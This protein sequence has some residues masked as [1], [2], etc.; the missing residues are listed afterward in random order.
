MATSV[1]Q[2]RVDDTLR[3]QAAAVYEELGIDLPTAI[4][5]FLKRS[6]AVNGVPFSMTL[7][8]KGYQAEQA[9]LSLQHLS[10]AAQK[11]GTAE[12]SLEEINAEISASRKDRQKIAKY[13][14]ETS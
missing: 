9:L 3:A 10:D 6:V 4:R 14:S 13:N 7:P 12:M 11:N 5:M 8:Q 2:V 1:M